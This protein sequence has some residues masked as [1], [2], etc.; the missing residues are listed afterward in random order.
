MA[1]GD[2]TIE[3]QATVRIDTPEE[4]VAF[5]HGGI[6]PYVLRQL[7]GKN[8]EVGGPAGP[9]RG[10]HAHVDVDIKAKAGEIGFDAC[11]IAPAGDLA[12][13]PLPSRWLARGYAGSMGYLERSA[14]RRADVRR[15]VPSATIVIVTA[16]IYNTDRPYSVECADPSRAHIARYAW[17]DDYHDVIGARLEALLAWMR[18]SRREPFEARAYVDTGPVQERVYARHAGI[19]WIGKNTCVIN[20]RARLVDLSR[21]DHLQSRPRARRAVARSVRDVHAVPRGVSDARDRGAGRARLDA[22][23]LVPDHRAPR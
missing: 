11:G 13:A 20:P 22:V 16:T 8:P 19:G 7:V 21:R 5:K 15:V 4:L 14:D 2:K 12:G 17:G 3:F 9:A 1:A 10:R 18:A 23:H 6:L